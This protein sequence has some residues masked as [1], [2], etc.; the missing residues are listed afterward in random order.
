MQISI[1]FSSRTLV[2]VVVMATIMSC[3]PAAKKA[4]YAERGERYFKN[5]QY[6][7]A[8]IEYLNVLK[9]DQ[10]DADAFARLGTM[11]LEEGAP[12]RAGGFLLKAIELAPNNIDNHLKLARVYLA[13]GR[14][15]DARKEVMTVLGKAPDNGE[16]L[17][18]LVE[19]SQKPEDLPATDQQMEKF[20]NKDNVYYLVASAAIAGKKA[21]LR[22]AEDA[23][24]RALAADPN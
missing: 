2:L 7:N 3:T 6:D 17:L 20:P 24:Q 19:A 18:I 14:A 10:R 11:W 22:G 5:G 13:I 1:N 23:L 4:R 21:D 15:A 12:L 16:A 8:K 9:V